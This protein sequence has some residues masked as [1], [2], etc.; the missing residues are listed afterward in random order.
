MCYHSVAQLCLAL[1][2]LMDCSAPGFPLLHHLWVCSNLRPW[3]WWCHPTISS[4]ATHFSFCPQSSPASGS[5]PINR[6]FESGGQSIGA[7][8]SASVLPMNI[9]GRFPF[10]LTGLI[11][12]LSNGLSSLHQHHSS[13]VSI[14]QHSTFLTVQLSNPYQGKLILNLKK[15]L[16]WVWIH[17][18]WSSNNPNPLLYIYL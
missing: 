2:D 4:S 14:L 10:R 12:L 18:N 17:W 7:S 13:K 6:L 8:A 3:N 5:F 1:W 11:S 16:I 9:Q 15:K